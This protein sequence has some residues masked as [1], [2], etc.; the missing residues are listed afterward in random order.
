MQVLAL[1]AEVKG[2]GRSRALDPGCRI[3]PG[4]AVGRGKRAEMRGESRPGVWGSDR[5]NATTALACDLGA[6]A[7]V[8]GP[9]HLFDLRDLRGETATTARGG[10]GVYVDTCRVSGGAPVFA[11]PLREGCGSHALQ[12]QRISRWGLLWWRTS[13]VVVR[14]KVLAAYQRMSGRP[15]QLP[16]PPPASYKFEP[17]SRFAFWSTLDS[18][19]GGIPYP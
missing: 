9:V 6:N 8:S 2:S 15:P 5:T 7:P 3:A 17:F 1:S 12:M 18:L 11:R 16:P 14:R 13:L 10:H 4:Q 19:L